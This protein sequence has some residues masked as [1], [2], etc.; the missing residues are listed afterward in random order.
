MEAKSY[1]E[2]YTD[3]CRLRDQNSYLVKK[4]KDKDLELSDTV[5]HYR[6]AQLQ[7][8]RLRQNTITHT[9]HRLIVDEARAERDRYKALAQDAI[10]QLCQCCKSVVCQREKCRWYQMR[11]AAACKAYPVRPISPC[12]KKCPNRTPTCR[13]TCPDYPSYEAAMTQ[14]YEALTAIRGADGLEL[15]AA[16]KSWLRKNKK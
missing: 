12:D 15:T 16:H 4:I 6:S 1:G 8:D 2:L 14:Y 9:A 5:A 3:W 10:S 11:G 13:G 7:I